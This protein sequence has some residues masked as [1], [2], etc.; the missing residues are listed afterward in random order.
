MLHYLL[1]SLL[2]CLFFNDGE[3]LL[4][5]FSEL[6]QNLFPI[7]SITG[8]FRLVKGNTFILQVQIRE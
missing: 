7:Y 6:Y 2:G 1:V 3:E 8:G 5:D 4:N